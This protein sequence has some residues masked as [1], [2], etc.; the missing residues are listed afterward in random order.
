MIIQPNGYLAT[1]AAAVD[2][3]IKQTCRLTSFVRNR[4]ADYTIDFK[5][6]KNSTE[7]WLL[8]V[9]APDQIVIT[10]SHSDY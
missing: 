6:F 5:C 1:E 10:Y 9:I 8:K 3:T 4:Y 2:P 7:R